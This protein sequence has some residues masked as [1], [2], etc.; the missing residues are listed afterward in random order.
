MQAIVGRVKNLLMDQFMNNINNRFSVVNG[1]DYSIYQTDPVGF[2]EDVLNEI[3]TDDVKRMMDSVR[4]HSIT[5]ARSANATGKTHGAARVAVWFYK[6]FPGSQVYTAAAPPFSNLEKLLWG[7]I[8]GM[9]EKY[10]GLFSQD[11]VKNLHIEGSSQ[12]FITGVTIPVSGT[13][14]QRQAKFSGK[15]APYLLFII[16]EGDAVPDEVFAAIES[17]LSGG[18]GRLLVMFNPRAEIGEVYRMER[19][20][21]AHVVTLS[22]LNHPNVISGENIVP[23]A[24]DR[25][26]TVRR[27]HQWTRPVSESEKSRTGCFEVP[28]FLV[29]AAAIDQ[30][31]KQLPPLQPGW[32]KITEPALSYMVLGTYPSQA[33]TQLISREWV[34]RAR[35]RW[36]CYVAE[37]G[38]G[39]PLSTLGVAGIDVAEHGVDANCIIFRYGGF[40]ERPVTWNGVDTVTTA[41]R[42][43]VECQNRNI[44][45]CNVDG[46]G[47]GAGVAPNMIR[48]QYAA[49]SVKV[50]S[51]PTE[52][53]ELGQFGL[54]RDQLWWACREWLRLDPGAMLPPDECLLEELL[55]PTYEVV[56]GKITIMKKSVMRDMLKR[57][58]DRAD[59]LCLS[60]YQPELLFPDL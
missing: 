36:D 50:A 19:D 23:G 45:R 43:V 56:N 4:D 46:T 31:G 16:D 37:N 32:R 54:L 10:T 21:R 44:L 2:V 8:G 6:V 13:A 47:V 41:D 55:C 52:T 29:G 59:A 1:A 12:S 49:V 51:K 60:F 15:H 33:T 39:P 3:L 30:A 27:I 28:A 35:S 20:G 22:A 9:V 26:T 5:I 25:S 38:E 57:S 34:D 24:V 40:I 53:T 7:E 11:A 17:C 42:A 58:P 18:F 14:A 48:N